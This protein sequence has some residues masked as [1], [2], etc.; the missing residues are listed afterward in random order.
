MG[1]ARGIKSLTYRS[2]EGGPNHEEG[3]VDKVLRY[4]DLLGADDGKGNHD[5]AEAEDAD[6]AG[7]LLDADLL[8][9]EDELEGHGHDWVEQSS[10]VSI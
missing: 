3:E 5:E 6:E 9:V 7:F 8:N 4:E 10:L 1:V 2:G